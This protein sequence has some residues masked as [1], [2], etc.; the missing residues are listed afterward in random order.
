[1]V[2]TATT[3]DGVPELLDALDRHRTQVAAAP[4]TAARLARAGSQVWSIVGDRIRQRLTQNDHRAD[5]EAV[6]RAVAAHELD[7]FA[8]ADRLLEDLGR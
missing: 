8:A 1:M 3:G 7:P 5:T 6:L 4:D 2:T